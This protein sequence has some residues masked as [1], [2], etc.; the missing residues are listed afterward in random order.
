VECLD[1]PPKI[2]ETREIELNE[3][4]QE[5]YDDMERTLRAEI[6]GKSIS[7]SIILVKLLR[8]SQIVSGYATDDLGIEREIENSSK[9]NELSDLIDEIDGK[10]IIWCHFIRN[11]KAVSNLLTKKEIQHVTFYSETK[12]RDEVIQKFQTDPNCRYFV[13]QTGTG[14]FGLNLTAANTVIY[15]SNGYSLEERLQSEDRCHRIGQTDKV[16]YVDIIAQNS[17]DESIIKAI[18]SKKS[19][20]DYVVDS[21]KEKK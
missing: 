4:E 14:G 6:M 21:W 20:A 2:Y 5:I 12:N 9:L 10:C 13:G 18:K 3:E 16:V 15:Y 17:I 19:I 11:I 8:L 1:L 7:A